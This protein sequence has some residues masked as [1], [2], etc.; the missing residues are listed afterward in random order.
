MHHLALPNNEPFASSLPSALRVVCDTDPG[1]IAVDPLSIRFVNL[2]ILSLREKEKRRI[3]RL[4]DTLDVTG[5]R[6]IDWLRDGEHRSEDIL[7]SNLELN[8]NR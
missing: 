6:R 7:Q 4:R 1:D 8:T 2:G 5:R 3:R